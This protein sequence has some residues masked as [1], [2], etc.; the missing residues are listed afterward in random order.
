M[1][2]CGLQTCCR[3]IA[4]E[5]DYIASKA[6]ISG[7]NEESVLRVNENMPDCR[8]LVLEQLASS[9][10]PLDCASSFLNREGRTMNFFDD[11]QTV[12]WTLRTR[13][14]MNGLRGERGDIFS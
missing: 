6:A 8:F 4:E 1:V 13:L 10:R 9:T 14:L 7:V 3:I 2:A 5:D 11:L 12:T